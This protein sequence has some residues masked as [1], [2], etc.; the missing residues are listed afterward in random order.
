VNDGAEAL[1]EGDGPVN[2]GAEAL[3][4]GG[5]P[6]NDTAGA[7]GIDA[8]EARKWAMLCHLSAL[9]GL[10]GNGIGFLIGPLVVWLLK[11]NDDP[12]I[13]EQGKEA[14]N[15]VLTMFLCLFVSLVLAFV[16]I[17]IPLLFI[18]GLW[19]VINPIIAAVKTSDGERYR[20]PVSIR[21][22]T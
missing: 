15:F 1:G 10:L 11:R 16:L 19:I 22:L 21:F 3:T 14:V 18:F 9:I 6:V 13:D 5:S 12:L 20:Y 7:A 17:G 4:E 8:R 2:D